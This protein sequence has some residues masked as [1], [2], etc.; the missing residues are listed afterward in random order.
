[1]VEDEVVQDDHSWA[2]SQCVDDPAVRLRV[3]ADVVQRNVG[4]YGPRASTPH[5]GNLH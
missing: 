1:M 4:G 3:I 5:D 2:A